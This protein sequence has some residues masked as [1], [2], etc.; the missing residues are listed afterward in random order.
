MEIPVKSFLAGLALASG[1]IV[2]AGAIYQS[3]ATHAEA[4]ASAQK[5]ALRAALTHYDANASGTLGFTPMNEF[6]RRYA[7][8]C[9]PANEGA[10]LLSALIAGAVVSLGCYIGLRIL[11]KI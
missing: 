10:D 2:S 4:C 8:V 3:H 6:E 5:V 1:L 9:Q 7:P 11:S